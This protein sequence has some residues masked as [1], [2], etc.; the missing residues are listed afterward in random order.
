MRSSVTETQSIEDCAYC[1]QMSTRKWG[2]LGGNSSGSINEL[3]SGM[4]L[5]LKYIHAVDAMRVRA[6]TS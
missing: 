5:Q 2:G 1:D 3:D 4:D 6:C